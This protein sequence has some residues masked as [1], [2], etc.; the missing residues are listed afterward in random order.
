MNNKVL[1][2]TINQLNFNLHSISI[3]EMK[4]FTKYYKHIEIE[5]FFS[6]TSLFLSINEVVNEL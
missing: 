3:K 1:S 4:N 5:N 6:F 2:D